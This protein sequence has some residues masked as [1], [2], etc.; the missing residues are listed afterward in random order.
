MKITLAL[1]AFL[2]LAKQCTKQNPYMQLDKNPHP[3][4]VHNMEITLSDDLNSDDSA[5]AVWAK[6]FVSTFDQEFQNY[7]PDKRVIQKLTLLSSDLEVKVIG[8][9]WCSDTRREVPRLCKVLYYMGVDASHFHYYRV[10]KNKKPVE[11]DFAS[12]R[13]IGSVPDMV[14]FK[15]G[16]EVGRIIE[17]P[18]KSIERDLLKILRK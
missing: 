1:F 15:N 8:G 4:Y 2:G 17:T 18:E 3:D 14:V 12:T 9:N 16:I 13:T 6:R 10:D 7:H 5:T 11:N